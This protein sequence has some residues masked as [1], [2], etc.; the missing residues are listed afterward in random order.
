M[1]ASVDFSSL[2]REQAESELAFAGVLNFANKLRSSSAGVIQKL[3]DANI[4]SVMLTG[5]SLY[6]GIH[7]A[8][9]SGLIEQHQSVIVASIKGGKIVWSTEDAMKIDKPKVDR[10]CRRQNAVAMSGETWQKILASEPEYSVKI[11]PLI[12]VY[13]RCSPHD[14]VSVVDTFVGLGFKTMMCGD[15]GND[16]GALKAAHVGIALS[17]S[18][19]S[20]VAPFTSLDKDIASVITVLKEGRASLAS[21]IA[22]FTFIVM[23]GVLSSYSQ[24]IFYLLDASF[25]DWMWVYVDGI[26]TISFA[27]TLPL[28]L[29]APELSNSRPS[30][31]L[32]SAQSAAS[33]IGMVLINFAFAGV[34]E[35]VLFS[36]DWFQCRKWNADAIAADNVLAV[37]DNYEVSV[38]FLMVCAQIIG[39]AI[40]M[41]FGYEFRRG[42]YRN[43]VFVAFVFGFSVWLSYIVFMPGNL[44]CYWRINCTNDHVL[45]SPVGGSPVPINNLFATTVMPEEFRWKMWALMVSNVLALSLYDYFVVNGIRRL[46][47]NKKKF[48]DCSNYIPVLETTVPP[49]ELM[50][51]EDK[52]KETMASGVVSSGDVFDE[53]F[54]ND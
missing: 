54:S 40:A 5:D 10:L 13:G 49:D 28:A 16:C 3:N 47:N 20:I 23:Y 31:S 48:T 41:N 36:Q 17:D 51:D 38:L 43:Y 33:I 21:T 32:A 14:K 24:V 12:R 9:E 50:E 35:W 18:D 1:P 29:P 2:T 6:T 27:L 7:V 22:V 53:E 46:K 37:S 25:S 15:G 8:R 52:T 11:A 44:S 30:S 4:Q 19:A 42:W 45:P 34:A 26:L 39:V